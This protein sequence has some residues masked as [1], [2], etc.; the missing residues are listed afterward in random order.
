MRALRRQRRHERQQ[1]SALRSTFHMGAF[2]QAGWCPAS[3]GQLY[4]LRLT[5]LTPVRSRIATQLPA[6]C[7]PDVPSC[8]ICGHHKAR[9]PA[10]AYSIDPLKPSTC[11]SHPRG[12]TGWGAPCASRSTRAA[13]SR[14]VPLSHAGACT[15]QRGGGTKAGNWG[16][17]I[18][19]SQS[20]AGWS[21]HHNQ[22]A[23]LLADAV[24][25]RRQ[26]AL[27]A[28]Q[29]PEQLINESHLSLPCS[30]ERKRGAVPWGQP[31]QTLPPH[32]AGAI[33]VAVHWIAALEA[34]E[35]CPCT[36]R[37]AARASRMTAATLLGRRMTA[38]SSALPQ[39]AAWRLN[40]WPAST[41]FAQCLPAVHCC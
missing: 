16:R 14:R 33:C 19:S 11:Q 3:S 31:P 39:G 30:L 28:M 29:A 20:A 4:R 36:G 5:A 7:V 40:P 6:Q 12:C 1:R 26:L 37:R 34:P 21:A 22:P 10:C 38:P 23:L 25:R 17:A 32:L 24:Q 18:T 13:C 9:C 8:L 27:Q 15:W 2:S 35:S 41:R